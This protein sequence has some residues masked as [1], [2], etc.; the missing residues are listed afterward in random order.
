MSFAGDGSG[1]ETLMEIRRA[2]LEDVITYMALGRAAQAWLRSRELGQYVPAAHEEYSGE[3][4]SKVEA[5]TLYV[6]RDSGEAVGFFSL[7]ATPSSWWPPAEAGAL[8][9]A[10][11]VVSLSARGR[12]IGSFIVEWCAAEAAR[13]KCQ[14][15]RLDCHADNSWLCAYYERHGFHLQGRVQQQPGYDGYLYQRMV[16]S[17]RA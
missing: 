15:L 1:V 14:F 13:R 16:A 2:Q 11:M 6:V 8:Y 7:D 3:I 17:Q 12:G 4:R 9:L 10:G 5:G